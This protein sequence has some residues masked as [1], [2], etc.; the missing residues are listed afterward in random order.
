MCQVSV[1]NGQKHPTLAFSLPNSQCSPYSKPTV[2]I[3][4]PTSGDAHSFLTDSHTNTLRS[5][6]SLMLHVLPSANPTTLPSVQYPPIQPLLPTAAT[7]ST[8]TT[9]DTASAFPPL[10][11]YTQTL[12]TRECVAKLC[13]QMINSCHLSTRILHASPHFTNLKSRILRAADSIPRCLSDLIFCY[14][15]PPPATMASHI[16]LT[17]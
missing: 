4:C 2:P 16:P 7:H 17:H 3:S 13:S 5:C 11:P 12:Q 8:A 6:L 1:R 14:S 10:L 9:P 15:P